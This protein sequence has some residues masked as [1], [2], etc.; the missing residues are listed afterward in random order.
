MSTIA[1]HMLDTERNG[2]GMHAG[3]RGD[4]GVALWSGRAKKGTPLVS[5][6]NDKYQSLGSLGRGPHCQEK[7]VKVDTCNLVLESS[8]VRTESPQRKDIPVRGVRSYTK[9]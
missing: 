6:S 7:V 4:A 2:M 3:Q 5:W 8:K 9:M 1:A